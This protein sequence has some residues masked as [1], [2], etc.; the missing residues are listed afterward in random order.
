[1]AGNLGNDGIEEA[2]FEL[3]EI[4]SLNCIIID[5]LSLRSFLKANKSL[6]VT[7]FEHFLIKVNQKIKKKS[8]SAFIKPKV[9]KNFS[10]ICSLL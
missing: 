8:L 6:I 1:M 2:N 7:D 4:I 3:S 10:E 5:Y 9:V